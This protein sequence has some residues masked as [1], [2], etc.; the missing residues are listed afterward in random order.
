MGRF[1][2]KVLDARC[3]VKSAEHRFYMA[4]FVMDT[5]WMLNDTATIPSWFP[6][7]AFLFAALN[8]AIWQSQTKEI[9]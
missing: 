7:L 5:C 9:K 4:W 8:L 2:H 1:Q 3:E 6:W